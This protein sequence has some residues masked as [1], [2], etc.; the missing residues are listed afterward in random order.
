MIKIGINGFGRI[1]RNVFRVLS[2]RKDLLLSTILLQ[3]LI[4]YAMI[5][6]MVVLLLDTSADPKNIKWQTASNIWLFI[7]NKAYRIIVQATPFSLVWT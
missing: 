3:W 6:V 5:L 4:C 2:Q 1:G 7:L